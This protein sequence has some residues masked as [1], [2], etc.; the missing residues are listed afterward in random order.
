VAACGDDGTD[1]SSAQSETTTSMS[2]QAPTTLSD[3][4]D[5]TT[6]APVEIARAAA[7][8]LIGTTE[9]L[10]DGATPLPELGSMAPGRYHSYRL[11]TEIVFALPFEAS[12]GPHRA[13]TVAF[14][15]GPDRILFISRYDHNE[16]R[17][18]DEWLTGLLDS[19][20]DVKET[21]WP[22][23]SGNPVRS[24]DIFAT[25]GQTGIS[26]VGALRVTPGTPHRIWVIDQADTEP[27]AI[28][29]GLPDDE[30]TQRVD[31]IVSSIELGA[32]IEDPRIGREPIEYGGTP[33]WSADAGSSYR[34]LL[35]GSTVLTAP[36]DIDGLAGGQSLE[37]GVP[38][39]FEGLTGP[40]VTIAAPSGFADASEMTGLLESL[41]DDGRISPLRSIDT[42][43]SILGVAAET[44]EF[45]VPDGG[46]VFL[47]T[48]EPDGW[49]PL[50]LFTLMPATSYQV[51][52][53]DVDG[54][55]AVAIARADEGFPADL[56]TASQFLSQVLDGL[57]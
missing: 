33:F 27:I 3:T 55:V 16:S 37:I 36:E 1:T 43:M 4:A 31:E 7:P 2:A 6:T 49:S 14:D 46:E 40:S 8:E 56:A 42:E 38:G 39:D 24:F 47:F 22:D 28:G 20:W 48:S 50:E 57:A 12:L 45:D 18:I 9:L 53:A 41:S 52:V 35:F 11:G 32:T 34:T 23:I 26:G 13:G 51:S 5:A 25:P 30:W 10:V 21:P 17:T 19:D 44:V 15:D 29:T 54:Q